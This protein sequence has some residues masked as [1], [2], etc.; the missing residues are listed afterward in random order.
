M[1]LTYAARMILGTVTA[2]VVLY[3]TTG[4]GLFG[5][6]ALAANHALATQAL[7]SF[8]GMVEGYVQTH[9]M[10]PPLPAAPPQSP[11]GFRP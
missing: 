3:V 9:P 1:I 7:T 11:P 6:R 5:P 2:A 10:T 4:V 8:E